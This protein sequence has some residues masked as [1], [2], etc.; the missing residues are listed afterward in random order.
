MSLEKSIPK[1]IK[2][3]NINIE[4]KRVKIIKIKKLI[5]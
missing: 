2:D 1:L 4:K 5:F 3:I